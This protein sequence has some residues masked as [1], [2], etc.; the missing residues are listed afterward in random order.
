M[1]RTRSAWLVYLP[2]LAAGCLASH[3]TAYAAVGDRHPGA[4]LA[5]HGDLAL[6]LAAAILVA[7]LVAQA[8]DGA[9]TRVRLPVAASLPPVTFALQEHLE[10]AFH[11][12]GAPWATGLEPAFLVGLALQVPFAVAA[13]VLAHALGSLAGAV[14]RALARRGSA[15][16][17]P[18]LLRP[19]ALS[20][21]VSPAP[22]VAY[23]G[24]APP[25]PVVP[26]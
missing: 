13:L 2:L 16:R 7:G 5:G 20:I 24:R 11:G 6:A 26:A 8:L 1:T 14:G 23:A 4:L 22:D 21:S 12:D 17:R 25:R 15:K 10:R 3:W 18:A 9:A 19:P